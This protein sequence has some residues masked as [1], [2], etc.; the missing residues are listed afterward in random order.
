MAA[1]SAFSAHSKRTCSGCA[2]STP[3]RSSVRRCSFFGSSTTRPGSSN[4]TGFRH[5]RPCGRT[6]FHSPHWLRK[7]QSGVSQ[8]G[9]G[10]IA[11]LRRV[12][13]ARVEVAKA[14]HKKWKAEVQAAVDAD[15][16]APTMPVEALDPGPFVEPRLFVSNSTVE[17]LA[18]LLQGRPRG[19][20]LVG[21]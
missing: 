5:P 19:L 12:H 18:V 3:S 8:I 9:G 11:D 15:H 13:E 17:R 21:D 4:G 10:T 6:S 20:S 7:T 16:R 2:P 14:A 1:P